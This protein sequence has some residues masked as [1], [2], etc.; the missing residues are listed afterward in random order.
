M[1]LAP[2]AVRAGAAVRAS[3]LAAWAERL[4]READNGA[5]GGVSIEHD[6]ARDLAALLEAAERLRGA[7]EGTPRDLESIAVVLFAEGHEDGSRKVQANANK[8]RAALAAVA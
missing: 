5:W 4:C 8:L 2:G 6:E 3:R 1:A 7:V